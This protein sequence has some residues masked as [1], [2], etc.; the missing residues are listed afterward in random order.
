MMSTGRGG[1]NRIPSVPTWHI[2][3]LASRTLFTLA[4]TSGSYS[5]LVTRRSLFTFHSV[6]PITWVIGKSLP[7]YA[8]PRLL[9]CLPACLLAHTPMPHHTDCIISNI[10]TLSIYLKYSISSCHTVLLDRSLYAYSRKA[11]FRPMTLNLLSTYVICHPGA[12]D[13]LETN[14][15]N[16]SP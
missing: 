12:V 4:F 8:R 14:I 11:P 5:S 13:L 2:S 10:I 7:P 16:H 9:A 6:N 1:G 3:R 15:V